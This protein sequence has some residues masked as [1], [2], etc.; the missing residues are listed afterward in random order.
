MTSRQQPPQASGTGAASS[1]ALGMR[2]ERQ[3]DNFRVTW[4]RNLPALR[5]ATGTLTIDDGHQPRDLQLDATQIA[6]GSVVYVSDSGDLTFRMRVRRDNGQQST[7][8]VRVVIAGRPPQ[9]VASVGPAHVPETK[10]AR[11]VPAIRAWASAVPRIATYR[12]AIPLRRIKP[13][14]PSSL[15]RKN[16]VVEVMG[17]VDAWGRVSEA[18]ALGQGATVPESLAAPV[19]G[20]SQ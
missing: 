8:S 1:S 3:T 2:V 7:E 10:E 4:N 11:L 9:P 14:T 6:S 5:N 19:N 13:E 17:R 18:H 16:A 12:P 15:V 20:A